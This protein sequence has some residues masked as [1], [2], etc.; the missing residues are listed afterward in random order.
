MQFFPPRMV[1]PEGAPPARAPARARTSRTRAPRTPRGR[2]ACLLGFLARHV[3]VHDTLRRGACKGF[4]RASHAR[5]GEKITKPRGGPGAPP[6]PYPQQQP[7]SLREPHA[8]RAA[9]ARGMRLGTRVR[10]PAHSSRRPRTASHCENQKGHGAR[11]ALLSSHQARSPR[12]TP[13]ARSLLR[14]PR[15]RAG[16]LRSPGCGRAPAAALLTTAPHTESRRPAHS[17]G[18]G[19]G[20]CSNN[21]TRRRHRR[22]PRRR[23]A[24]GG[25]RR[26]EARRAAGPPLLHAAGG[27]PPFLIAN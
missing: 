18:L 3:V 22:R 12:G 14:A 16:R 8:A 23:P 10:A 9:R 4:P 21:N 15:A 6:I 11:A 19:S 27:R 13:A 24:A 26:P 2:A 7:L 1:L 17:L 5:A 20:L 25:R